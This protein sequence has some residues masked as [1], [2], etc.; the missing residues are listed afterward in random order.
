MMQESDQPFVERRVSDEGKP[1]DGTERRQFV[2][3]QADLPDD[4]KELSAAID[5]FKVQRRR[6]FIT[7]A[8]VLDIVKSLGYHK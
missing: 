8:E 4:V 1:T 5:A 6:R 7:L 3:S 2:D